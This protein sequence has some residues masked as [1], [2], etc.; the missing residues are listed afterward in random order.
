MKKFIV[1]FVLSFSLIT[2]SRKGGVTDSTYKPASREEAVWHTVCSKCH[3]I[4]DANPCFYPAW[5]WPRIVDIMQQKKGGNQFTDRQKSLILK[6]LV[7][8]ARPE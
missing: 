5:D 1:L 2:C 7:A 3:S 8:R 4:D 6:Y